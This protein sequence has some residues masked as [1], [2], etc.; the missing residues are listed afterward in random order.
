VAAHLQEAAIVETPFTDEDRLYG[1]LHVVV[2]AAGAGAFA[3]S[4]LVT[5]A[6]LANAITLNVYS[7]TGVLLEQH[8]TAT[9]LTLNQVQGGVGGSG[10]VFGLTPAEQAQLNATLAANAGLEVF[11]VGATFANAQGGLDVIQVGIL[12]PAIPEASTWAMMVLGF[13]GVGFVAYRRRG[14]GLAFRVA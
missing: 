12:T 6:N 13:L 7:A 8:T 5:N 1:G 10:L 4:P 2:D 3:L 11:T 9:G 14:Q